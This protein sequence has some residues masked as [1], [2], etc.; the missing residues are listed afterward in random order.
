MTFTSSTSAIVLVTYYMEC[1]RTVGIVFGYRL[2][3]LLSPSLNGS[4]IVRF[5]DTVSRA[6]GE[7]CEEFYDALYYK[8]VIDVTGLIEVR[9]LFSLSL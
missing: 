5:L 4:D 7:V 8:G 3:D 1:H 2:R 6:L 9:W